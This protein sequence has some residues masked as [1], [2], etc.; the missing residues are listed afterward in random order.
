MHTF[1]GRTKKC[2]SSA[3]DL[4]AFVFNRISVSKHCNHITRRFHVP[5]LANDI[6]PD[7]RGES[8]SELFQKI[9][10]GSV[11]RDRPVL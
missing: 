11:R 5:V 6:I 2:D 7:E 9:R 10:K 1:R 3:C 8:Y 4:L